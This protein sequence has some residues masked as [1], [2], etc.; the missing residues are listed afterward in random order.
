MT[1]SFPQRQRQRQRGFTLIEAV[2]VIVITGILAGVVAIFIR[3]PVQNYV[4]SAARAELT[5]A[6][7]TAMRRLSRDVR[8]ALPNSLRVS[9]TTAVEFMLTKTGGRYLSEDDGVDNTDKASPP[10]SFSDTTQ[11][12][13]RVVGAMPTGTQ[14]VLAGDYIVVY[15][16]GPGFDPSDAYTQK[17]MALVSSVAGNI[18]T[19]ATNPFASS[20]STTMTSPGNRFQVVNTSVMYV[21]DTTA[22]TLTRYWNYGPNA[23]MVVPPTGTSMQKALLASNVTECSF[24]YSDVKN[25]RSALLGITL[26]LQRSDK[27]EAALRLVNQV[28]V[29]NIP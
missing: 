7:D 10:L 20:G 5:D 11:K 23:S 27:S 1:A 2:V 13:F 26:G 18:V 21:C 14:A 25:T 22:R 24:N 9:G 8:R 19:L 15:N 16:L 3:M 17:N 4:D 28:R 6:A 29:D 12:T